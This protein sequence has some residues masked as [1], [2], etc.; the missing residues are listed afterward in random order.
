MRSVSHMQTS[1]GPTAGG[2]HNDWRGLQASD[3]TQKL[4]YRNSGSTEVQKPLATVP[5]GLAA[6]EPFTG[7]HKVASLAS[8]VIALAVEEDHG[9]ST[10]RPSVMRIVPEEWPSAQ[11]RAVHA[12]PQ[13][14]EAHNVRH[15]TLVA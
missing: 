10:L 14:V 7:L 9:A 11:A 3:F 13:P 5:N 15:E 2:V 12:R 6:P 8:E 1:N 4:Q